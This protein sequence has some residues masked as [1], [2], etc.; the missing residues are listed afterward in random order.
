MVIGNFKG[1]GGLSKD[2]VCKGKYEAKLQNPEG[3]GA[4]TLS[5]EEEVRGE[6]IFSGTTQDKLTI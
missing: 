4:R 3:W 5:W 2:I 6:W 1:E